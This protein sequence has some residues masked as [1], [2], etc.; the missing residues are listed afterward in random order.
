MPTFTFLYTGTIKIAL[1]SMEGKHLRVLVSMFW[2]EPSISDY[3]FTKLLKIPIAILRQIQVR[4]I[5]YLDDTLLM[6]QT[7]NGLEIA[8][9]TLIFLL[10]GLDFVLN[11]K[12]LFWCPYKR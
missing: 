1:I 5:I 11:L 10:Q 9:D 7:I 6:S 3:Y 2:S 12:N 4:I 8:R